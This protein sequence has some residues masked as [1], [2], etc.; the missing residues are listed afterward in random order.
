M[1]LT[2]LAIT[3]AEMLQLC[4]Q[5]EQRIARQY[6]SL[7]KW[8]DGLRPPVAPKVQKQIDARMAVLQGWLDMVN[9]ARQMA[10]ML[11][12]VQANETFAK[13]LALQETANQSFLLSSQRLEDI[14]KL[15]AYI[16]I[17]GGDPADAYAL[18]PI[19][20]KFADIWRT[21]GACLDKLKYR[22]PTPA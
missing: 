19:I 3:H 2:Q 6:N 8:A 21:Q 7:Q 10:E 1:S 22:Q 15:E 18:E 4:D 11:D 14:D 17:L 20:P 13:A 16:R 5:H 12:M 9:A